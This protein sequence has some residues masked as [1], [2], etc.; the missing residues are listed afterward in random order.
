M[1]L[2]SAHLA[3][4]DLNLLVL[5]SVVIEERSVTRA[6]ERLRLTPSAI[7]HGLKRLR[8][9]L[10][11]PLFLRTP[12]GVVPTDRAMAIADEVSDILARVSSVVSVAVPFDPATSRRR[13][14]VG[15]PDAISSVLLPLLLK[16]LGGSAPGIDVSLRQIMP[17]GPVERGEAAWADT[18]DVLETRGVDVAVIPIPIVPARF[19]ARMLYREEF[20]VVMREGH[21]FARRPSLKAY[22]EMSHLL[23]SMSGDPQG[24]VDVLLAGRGLSRRVA[25][26]VPSFMMALSQVADTELIATL[27][28]KLVEQHA[29]RF[30]LEAV[31]LPLKRAPDAIQAV[32]TKAAIEDNGVRWLFEEIERALGR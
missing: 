4:V 18:L 32:V 23:V 5:F 29:A 24:M 21:P 14:T 22:C 26:T 19:V 17:Q 6:A 30:G 10:N 16:R 9:L 11:D 31:A 8:G 28:R 13:F 15:A 20:V 12:K 2:N 3:R 25:V 7:S 27:P 1:A